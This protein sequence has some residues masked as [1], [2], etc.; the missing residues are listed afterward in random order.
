VRAF[1]PIELTMAC[2][3]AEATLRRLERAYGSDAFAT[4]L[5]ESEC[6]TV[7]GDR[8]V[9]RPG[10]LHGAT[11]R[12]APEQILGHL[13]REGGVSH[14]GAANILRLCVYLNRQT[15]S[16][17]AAQR[18]CVAGWSTRY[19]YPPDEPFLAQREDSLRA[20]V[21]QDLAPTVWADGGWTAE[22]QHQVSETPLLE[23]LSA[24]LALAR[25]EEGANLPSH[26]K[27]K[28]YLGLQLF[29]R[30]DTE[31]ACADWRRRVARRKGGVPAF[32]G[33]VS[34][35]AR[36]AALQGNDLPTFLDSRFSAPTFPWLNRFFHTLARHLQ[37][38]LSGQEFADL[39]HLSDCGA[40]LDALFWKATES[41]LPPLELTPPQPNRVGLLSLP[42]LLNDKPLEK[43]WRM[44]LES[45]R[46]R[47]K[48]EIAQA[49]PEQSQGYLS[50]RLWSNGIRTYRHTDDHDDGRP[51]DLAKLAKNPPDYLSL[52]D[53]IVLGKMQGSRVTAEAVRALTGHPHLSF[54]AASCDLVERPQK[55]HLERTDEGLRL[56]L[57][58]KLENGRLF[59][60]RRLN[61][62][63]VA[64][65]VPSPWN[66]VLGPLLA[67]G[68]AVPPEGEAELREILVGWAGGMTVE[69][70]PDVKPLARSVVRPDRMVLRVLPQQSGL[71][72]E[73]VAR[74]D[75]LA[76]PA[77]RG[78][79][80]EIV[81]WN[82]QD[83]HVKRDFSQEQR[84][85]EQIWDRCPLLP[86]ELELTLAEL[87]PALDLLQQLRAASVPLEWSEGK[88]WKVR[89]TATSQSLSLSSSKG[90]GD[91][92]DITGSLRLDESKVLALGRAL[93]LARTYPGRYLQLNDGDFVRL[94][95]RLRQQLSDLEQLLDPHGTKLRLSPLA[96]PALEDIQIGDVHSDEAYGS[97]LRR[98]REA[99]QFR[100]AIPRTLQAELRDYQEVGFRWLAQRAKLRV[101]ACLA[102]DMGLG[103]TIQALTLM[104]QEQAEGP[105]LVVCPTS[106]TGHWSD[107]I[108]QF[109]PTLEPRLYEGS[110]RRA[111]LDGLGPG[112]VVIA[113]Y[114]ILLGDQPLLGG[115]D[116]HIA[117]LDE[118]QTIKNPKSKTA[119]ACFLLKAAIRL[120]TT[121]TP[122]ENRLTE[123]WSLFRFLNPGLLGSLASFQRRFES[124]FE[125]A[126]RPRLRR[127]VTPFLLRRMKSDVL[128]ELPERTELTLTV[129]L[130]RD[131][132]ALYESVRRKAQDQLEEGHT[133]QLLAHLT[134][135]RQA[136]CHPRLLVPDSEVSS[137]KLK[138]FMELLDH[139][140]AG[141]HRAL[142]FSQFTRL[143][144]LVEE[145]LKADSISYLRLDGTTPAYSRQARVSAFQ[146]GQG[147]LFLISLKAGGTGLNLT[148]ADYVVH[149]DPWWNPAAEDQATDRAH[150]IGQTRPVTVYR[151]LTRDTIEEKVLQLH[152]HKR[153]LA[154]D[155]L[156]G[157]HDQAPLG[158]HELRALVQ[159]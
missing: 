52:Q 45:L 5:A 156:N 139:L 38:P 131:E 82:G 122:I 31:A 87:D 127:L 4:A 81:R 21:L 155:I 1:S 157:E 36:L 54:E 98:F 100:A 107:Q 10:Q 116:W 32:P 77:L 12:L 47:T 7:N 90:E 46:R 96:V 94:D 62:R 143:L 50:W 85:L 147:D 142:V 73:W 42:D 63:Q 144:D 151:I 23:E 61:E 78:P 105:H 34:V 115:I 101:G 48:S 30:G 123:L 59:L 111:L 119:R 129:N 74:D 148:A 86:R 49:D 137:S 6:L 152:G 22:L 79:E 64:L 118:A 25:G 44:W 83:C 92:F 153:D 20:L 158:I 58:P 56:V 93:E 97:A 39:A 14:S 88:Q 11:Q 29:L 150:R 141:N 159:R 126:N 57:R 124:T 121:G 71:H 108:R 91:W 106:V 113:S 132:R 138:A 28:G 109:C 75:T 69:C 13:R 70:G 27:S 24:A 102:D 104:I 43:G 2:L 55:L 18:L 66:P 53:R 103:K 149:L 19:F 41:R 128:K 140:R 68:Q 99:Q 60:L 80:R 145:R 17:P 130:S 65:T 146:N 67:L 120:A 37:T 133:M 84:W 15:P 33:L 9:W 72:L 8:V 117:L 89:G 110:G 51:V 135:L 16:L 3:G 114:R 154:R 112:K 134:S 125:R 40:G 76:F 136:C 95:Q 26:L 35:F